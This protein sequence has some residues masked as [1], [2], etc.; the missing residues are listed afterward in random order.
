[1]R[2]D[3]GIPFHA[4]PTFRFGL[5][6]FVSLWLRNLLDQRGFSL[7]RRTQWSLGGLGRSLGSLGLGEEF[8]EAFQ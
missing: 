7:R 8:L 6:S 5:R 2:L 3:G 1:M 4:S